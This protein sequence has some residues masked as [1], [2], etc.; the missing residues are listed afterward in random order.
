MSRAHRAA[1]GIF[2]SILHLLKDGSRNTHKKSLLRGP[3]PPRLGIPT[4]TATRAENKSF[5][6]A[7]QIPLTNHQTEDTYACG[8]RETRHRDMVS[9]FEFGSGT[10]C[11]TEEIESLAYSVV[12]VSPLHQLNFLCT[13]QGFF[14]FR[15]AQ[16]T[17]PW[18]L[19]SPQEIHVHNLHT[20]SSRE[21]SARPF[22]HRV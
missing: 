11:A 5:F 9:T 7:F 21:S 3:P 15:N 13:F 14:L 20:C 4:Q 16:C 2:I 22:R 12:S 1:V 17:S 8:R 6:Q 18:I 19:R 10:R